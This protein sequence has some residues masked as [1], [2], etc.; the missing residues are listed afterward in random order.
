[1]KVDNV[2]EDGELKNHITRDFSLTK[3]LSNLLVAADRHS[4]MALKSEELEIIR[5]NKNTLNKIVT[6]LP[7][8][9]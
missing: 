4:A 2:V 9:S 1:M 8:T 6:P 7:L 5:K 3:S